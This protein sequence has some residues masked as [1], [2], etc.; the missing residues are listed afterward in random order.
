[1]SAQDGMQ[2]WRRFADGRLTPIENVKV[3]ILTIRQNLDVDFPDW[4][5][6]YDQAASNFLVHDARREFFVTLR[7][8]LQNAQLGFVFIRDQL[9]DRNWW[10][11]QI[12][13]FCQPTVFQAL[14]EHALMLK[15]FSFHAIAMATEETLRAIVRA[16]VSTFALDP[17]R[18]PFQAIYDR[19]LK[20]TGTQNC[21]DVFELIR[22]TRNT[23]H[24]NGIY[25]PQSGANTTV[26]CGDK[27][28]LF[29]VD[30][31]LLWM[32]DEFPTWIADNIS[33]VMEK[34]VRSSPIK[35][36]PACPRGN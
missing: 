10:E 15:F 4:K 11:A 3:S 8:A 32:G 16:D 18:T 35:E 33:G 26:N 29:E 9:T 27:T 22:L 6:A 24:N 20:L 21:R 2:K 17:V 19:F 14:R 30:K 25:R 36:V 13:G 28:F 1:M 34:I 31:P 12:G 7:V 5:R 23:I